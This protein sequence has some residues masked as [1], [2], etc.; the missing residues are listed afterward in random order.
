MGTAGM[1]EKAISPAPRGAQNGPAQPDT[2]STRLQVV[3]ENPAQPRLRCVQGSKVLKEVALNPVGFNALID[4]DLMRK[5]RSLKVGALHDWVELDGELFRLK[6]AA[7]ELEKVLNERY[8]APQADAEQNVA[9]YPNPA[10]PTGFDLQFPASPHGFPENR[11]R[12]LND[13]TVGILQDTE[14]CPVLRKDILLTLAPPNIVFKTRGSDG[15]E[16]HL[17]P[18]PDTAVSA[19]DD[20]GSSQTIDLSQPVDLLHLSAHQLAAVFNHPAVNRRAK[21]AESAAHHS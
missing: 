1:S 17:K 4:Q 13:E 8:V 7:A 20:N 2:E 18:G 21:L 11:R 19:P 3:T 9:V 5:P 12:H 10:S 16:I 14:N 6:N 15:I